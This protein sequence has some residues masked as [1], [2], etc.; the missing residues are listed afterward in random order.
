MTGVA[1][2]IVNKLV[3]MGLGQI[4]TP[5]TIFENVLP[6]GVGVPDDCLVVR[7]LVGS[8]P[9]RAMGVTVMRRPGIQVY[10]RKK[11]YANMQT[12]VLA[13]IGNRS[14]S[15]ATGLD[16]FK[17]TLGGK[18]I[19]HMCLAY[20]PVYMGQ[21]ENKLHQASVVFELHMGV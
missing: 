5:V 13:I 18:Q 1:L 10:V 17:G 12:A 20:E 2:L 21:D 16:N 14:G 4:T 6:G 7:D 19:F 8:N 15:A 3:T 11:L 9:V